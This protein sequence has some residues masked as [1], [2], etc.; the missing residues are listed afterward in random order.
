MK[1]SEYMKAMNELIKTNPECLHY[2]LITST[3][4]EGNGFNRVGNAAHIVA[5]LECDEGFSLG[6]I[7]IKVD[8]S[9]YNVV[10]LN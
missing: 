2:N 1:L 7:Y 4:D 8:N 3:D 9:D 5:Y 10:C 6:K